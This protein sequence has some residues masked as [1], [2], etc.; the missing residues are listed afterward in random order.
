MTGVTA[1]HIPIQKAEYRAPRGAG[2]PSKMRHL[3]KP[4]GGGGKF[5]DI[6]ILEYIIILYHKKSNPP[7][8]FKQNAPPFFAK[9]QEL[10]E[11]LRKS[12]VQNFYK[13]KPTL[14]L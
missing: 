8:C 7:L 14:L 10:S 13:G 5:Y 12:H 6:Y 4:V 3:G 9:L 11:I 1:A 2:R